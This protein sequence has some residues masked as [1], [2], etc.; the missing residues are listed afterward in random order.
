MQ[1]NMESENLKEKMPMQNRVLVDTCILFYLIDKT[2]EEKHRKALEWFKAMKGRENLFISLQNLREFSNIALK[3]SS[4]SPKEINKLLRLFA[5]FFEL[6]YDNSDDIIKANERAG[7][8]RKNFWDALLVSTM[9]R[10]KIRTIL[11]EN[12]KDFEKFKGVS[13]VNP[14]R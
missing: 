14:F 7:R 13:A 9:R 4:L 2:C 11:T 5:D 8:T 12:T 1:K 3:K 6:V 10:Y